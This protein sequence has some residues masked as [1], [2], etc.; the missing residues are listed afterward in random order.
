MEPLLPDYSRSSAVARNSAMQCIHV[1]LNGAARAH[2][3]GAG[4]LKHR[5]DFGPRPAAE[6]LID[7]NPDTH[8]TPDL[9]PTGF[10]LASPT[11]CI[12]RRFLLQHTGV[13]YLDM[14]ATQIARETPIGAGRGG[15]ETAPRLVGW[16]GLAAAPTFA[17][18]GLRTALFGAHPSMLGTAMRSSSA[19]SGMTLMYLLM[20]VF[21]SSPWVKMLASRMG[22]VRPNGS[23]RPAIRPHPSGNCGTPGTLNM[24]PKGKPSP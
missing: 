22:R 12:G 14:S 9:L 23:P 6:Q 24:G 11:A 5:D 8:V 19:M 20:S 2:R 21:H 17:L 4:R 3:Y 15:R 7:W 16:L 1:A 10:N 13:R 18:M